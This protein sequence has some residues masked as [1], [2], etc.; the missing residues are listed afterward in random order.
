MGAKEMQLACDL[1]KDSYQAAVQP[2]AGDD[3]RPLAAEGDKRE[4]A[5]GRPHVFSLSLTGNVEEEG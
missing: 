2:R 1:S 5:E 3:R 4:D